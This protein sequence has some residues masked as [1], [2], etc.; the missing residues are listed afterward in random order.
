VEAFAPNQIWRS[1]KAKICARSTAGW[2]YLVS[3]VDY[4]TRETVRWNL[5]HR[6][7]AED[8]S[9]AV[10]RAVL[11]RLPKGSHEPNIAIATDNCTHFTS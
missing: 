3:V 1:D 8:S 5:L 6:R 9:G 11:T 10:K 2:A 7:R 4:C